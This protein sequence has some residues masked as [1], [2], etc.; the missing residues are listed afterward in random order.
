[1]HIYIY[2]YIL[3]DVFYTY[4]YENFYKSCFKES[5]NIE[6]KTYENDVLKLKSEH[7]VE[8]GRRYSLGKDPGR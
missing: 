3:R 6:D 2:I 1:M 7:V 4:I 8:A 5:R